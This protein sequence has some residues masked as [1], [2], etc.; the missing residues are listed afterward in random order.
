MLKAILTSFLY[1]FVFGSITHFV[2]PLVGFDDQETSL[3]Y[4]LSAVIIFSGIIV[5]ALEES[6]EAHN[7]RASERIEKEHK[8]IEQQ[9]DEQETSKIIEELAELNKKTKDH[10]AK[11]DPK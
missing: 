1:A 10:L 11:D 3:L 7:Q 5:P 9:L 6:I 2:S 4:M 8:E